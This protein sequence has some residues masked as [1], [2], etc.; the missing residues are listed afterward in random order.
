MAG[1]NKENGIIGS[2]KAKYQ[3]NGGIVSSNGV[4][5]GIMW[6]R[7][8]Q[9]SCRAKMAANGRNKSSA[10]SENSSSRRNGGKHHR[11]ENKIDR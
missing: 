4:A 8:H 7:W 10:G 9:S 1:I 6:R 11:S 3:R 2:A 5:I